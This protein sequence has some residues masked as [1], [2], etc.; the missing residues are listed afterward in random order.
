MTK[1]RF[2]EIS[3]YL[4]L[5]DSSKEYARDDANYDRLYKVRSIL[6]YVNRKCRGNFKPTKNISVDE[7]MVGF[8]GR[9]SLDST[10]QLSPRSMELKF[11][12]LP[13]GYDVVTKMI[14]PFMNK[15]HHVYFDNFFSS[16]KLL[17]HLETNNTYGCATVR[18]NRKDL[19]PCAKDILRAGEKV[20]RQKGHVVFTKW[21]DKRDI[22]VLSTNCSPL[23]V[24]LVVHR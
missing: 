3:C 16:V 6:D 23:G 14:R 19:L 4:H 18:F 24:D 8:R 2:K 20:V 7:G 22:S 15:N 10:R 17:E 9:S 13:I 1:N 11:G 12:W 21:H 5:N